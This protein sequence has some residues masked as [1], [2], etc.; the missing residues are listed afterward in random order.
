VSKNITSLV[1]RSHFQFFAE[2][3]NLLEQAKKY[4]ARS[5]NA[6]LSRTYWELGRRIVEHEQQGRRR[7]RYGEALIEQLASDLTVKFGWVFLQVISGR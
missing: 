2:V 5:V 6:I 1:D 7:A 4:Y 3:A